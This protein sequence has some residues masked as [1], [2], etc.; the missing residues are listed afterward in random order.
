MK[1][2]DTE[3]PKACLLR[4]DWRSGQRCPGG[5]RQARRVEKTGRTR[6]ARS[7]EAHCKRM[8]GVSLL[9]QEDSKKQK[10]KKI[11]KCWY[12]GKGILPFNFGW[13]LPAD[14]PPLLPEGG[15]LALGRGALSSDACDGRNVQCLLV[16]VGWGRRRRKCESKWCGIKNV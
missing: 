5:T 10:T 13:R 12:V 16:Q 1:A 11:R 14:F 15:R 4:R 8:P 2:K 7:P 9:R 6:S 3:E